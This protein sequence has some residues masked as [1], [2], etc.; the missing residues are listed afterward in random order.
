MN[1]PDVFHIDIIIS[2]FTEFFIISMVPQL[3]CGMQYYLCTVDTMYLWLSNAEYVPYHINNFGKLLYW[4]CVLWSLFFS[5][6]LNTVYT[7][8]ENGNSWERRRLACLW[9]WYS[10]HFFFFYQLLKLP[11]GSRVKSAAEG[12]RVILKFIPDEPLATC[13]HCSINK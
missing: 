3:L 5:L 8:E 11:Q 9:H 6:R 2:S 4:A 12:V 10:K 13:K 1:I 7:K